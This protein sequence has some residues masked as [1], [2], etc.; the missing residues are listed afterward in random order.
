[1]DLFVQPGDAGCAMGKG[2][3]KHLLCT[4]IIFALQHP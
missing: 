1:M 2:E 4:V 3:L